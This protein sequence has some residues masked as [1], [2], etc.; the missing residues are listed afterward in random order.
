MPHSSS[1]VQTCAVLAALLVTRLLTGC[2]DLI[3]SL[4]IEPSPPAADP[5]EALP[6]THVEQLTRG[7]G[8]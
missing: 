5:R 6:R 2:A 7:R 4:G 3:G 1:A 8:G